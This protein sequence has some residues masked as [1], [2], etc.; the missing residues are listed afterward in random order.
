MPF[1]RSTIRLC[2]SAVAQKNRPRNS[3]TAIVTI[4]SKSD[5]DYLCISLSFTK[6]S[7]KRA[8]ISWR[9]ATY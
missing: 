5:V 4:T 7:S 8:P 6:S 3:G 1:G 9:R 2:A